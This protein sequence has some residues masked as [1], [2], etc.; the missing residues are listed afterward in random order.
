MVVNSPSHSP[1]QTPLRFHLEAE[2][3]WRS[4][5]SRPVI[6]YAR[7]ER[8]AVETGTVLGLINL[9]KDEKWTI[10]VM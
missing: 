10:I 3:C 5:R 2:V 7:P 1:E 8:V 6:L 9:V 4:T